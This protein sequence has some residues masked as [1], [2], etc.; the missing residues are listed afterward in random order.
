MKWSRQWAM[1]NRQTFAIR[2]IRDF[3]FRYSSH[4]N[5]EDIIDPFAGWSEIAGVSNDLNPGSPAQFHMAASDFCAHIAEQKKG[6]YGLALFDPPYSPRQISECYKAAGL[7][8]GMTDTQNAR[9]M[10]ECKRE[11]RKLIPV[12]GHVLSF[13]WNSA[14]MGKEF[15]IEEIMLVCHGVGH[16]DTICMAEK[17]IC[18][19][20]ELEI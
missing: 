17:R 3:I 1:P 9:L 13:G 12:G 5:K 15:E 18:E 16:N 11:L 6:Y 4:L 19:T 10:A 14:G 2:P 8:A 20:I 7:T